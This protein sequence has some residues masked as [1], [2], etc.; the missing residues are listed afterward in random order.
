N[1]GLDLTRT[2]LLLSDIATILG[3]G[4]SIDL[5]AHR[6]ASLLHS[7]PLSP[8]VAV[9]SESGCEFQPEPT[10]ECDTTPEGGFDMHLRGSDR[11]VAIR[12]S[13]VHD[14]EEVSLL[15]GLADVVQAAVHR[16][17]GTEQEDDET[18]WPR[19]TL[20]SDDDTIFRSPRM[21]ELVKVAM[22]LAST[23]LPVLITGETGTGKEIFARMIHE[24]S[25]VRR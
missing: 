19:T 14:L 2:A 24:H 16:T 21:V 6:T 11:R 5:L 17:A 8:R 20:A 22:R 1:G 3:A 13:Q 23:D 9:E 10:A 15:R 7:T 12:V 18:L 25:K 4:H